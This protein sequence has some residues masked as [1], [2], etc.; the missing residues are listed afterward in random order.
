[1]ARRLPG[2]PELA[3]RLAGL[4]LEEHVQILGMLDADRI[5]DPWQR[6]VRFHQQLPHA[7]EL[8]RA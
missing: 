6:P 5:G 2:L 7:P 8:D 4:P 3:G 1:M